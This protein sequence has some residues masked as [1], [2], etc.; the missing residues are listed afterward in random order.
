MTTCMTGILPMFQAVYAVY[1]LSACMYELY[2][3]K[4]DAETM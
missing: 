2:K 1:A 3:Y 4:E